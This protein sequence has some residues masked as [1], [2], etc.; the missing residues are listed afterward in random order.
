[1]SGQQADVSHG[2]PPGGHAAGGQSSSRWWLWLGLVIGAVAVSGALAAVL[3]ER[4]DT[5]NGDSDDDDD[6]DRPELELAAEWEHAFPESYSGPVWITVQAPDEATRTITIVWG[7]WQRTIL[8]RGTEPV[9][10]L[11]GKGEGPTVPTWVG[12]EPEAQITFHR[13]T[14]PD[15]AVDVNADWE[16]VVD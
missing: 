16:R 7:P 11:F 12:T 1:M 6:G 13:G 8:H 14:P 3:Y 15:G 10:Y 2:E 9:S 4:G 5:G